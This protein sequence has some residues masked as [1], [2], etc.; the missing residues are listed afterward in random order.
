[1]EIDTTNE[2]PIGSFG[3][4]LHPTTGF[5]RRRLSDRCPECGR[6]YGFPLTQHP[7]SIGDFRIERPLG[8]GFYGAI[9]LASS[10]PFERPN[11]LKVIPKDVY[12][13]H[14]KDFE[15]ECRLH[16]E[17][18]K[19]TEHVVGIGDF[20]E[21]DVVFGDVNLRCH[22]AVL[23]YVDGR[24]MD[25]FLSGGG[26][27]G[28]RTLAQLAIDIFRLLQALEHKGAYHNDLH[29]QN[30]MVEQ[31]PP[32]RYRPEAIDETIR[33]V[34][35]DLGSLADHSRSGPPRHALGDLTS[36]A[37]FL[38]EFANPLLTN[39]DQTPDSDYRLASTLVELAA[40]ISGE[41]ANIRTPDYEDFI[42]QIRQAYVEASSP[43]R[44]PAGLTRLNDAYNA[45]TLH[46][47]FVPRLLVDPGGEWLAAISTG[48]PQVITDR[49]SVV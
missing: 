17:V 9:Y 37:A 30:L 26:G 15:R 32:T 24:E 16:Y 18:A 34:A 12:A 22:V 25:K 20:F 33:L 29:H 42:S 27:S 46:P 23:E 11:V 39:P 45:Q 44:P 14:K 8:R 31:L 38:V 3:C 21:Y 49:K 19:G 35:V 28:A 13:F 41:S 4:F 1:M 2:E 47:C 40:L 5:E 43:W 6:E 48:G 10:G 36:A 7:T